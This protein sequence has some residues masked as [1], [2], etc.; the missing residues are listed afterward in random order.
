MKLKFKGD[1]M[2]KSI[3]EMIEVMEHYE[4]GGEV[5]FKINNLYN[6]EW[7]AATPR[8]NWDAFEYRIKKEKITIEKWLI[9]HDNIK[10]VVEA[11]DID[12]WLKP[13]ATTKKLKL[14]ESYE[15]EI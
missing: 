8:W 9:E 12:S 14:I 13:F 2:A 6:F 3:K 5:E 4:N 7:R 1:I 15:V 11:S 10:V